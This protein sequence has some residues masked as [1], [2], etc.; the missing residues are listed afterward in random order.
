M[1]N[2][3]FVEFAKE[4]ERRE[5]VKDDVIVSQGAI[6][7]LNP[8][9][10]AIGD[11]HFGMNKYAQNQV[12]NK[13]G[14][15]VK[16]YDKAATIPGL[17]E[18]NI[19]T[20]LGQEPQEKRFVRTLDG[21]IR[22]FLSDRF[23]PLDNYEVMSESIVPVLQDLNNVEIKSSNIS[24]TRMYL[25]VIFKNLV[26]E[27][28]GDTVAYGV[29][30][31]NSEVGAGAFDIRSWTW[32]LRCTNGAVHE[33]IFRRAH[34]G[35]VYDPEEEG[36]YLKSDTIQKILIAQKGKIRD[37]L[38]WAIKGDEFKRIISSYEAADNDVIP[39]SSISNTVENV[40]R[41]YNIP[42]A[43]DRIVYNM[44][45]ERLTRYGLA[46][47]ITALSHSEDDIDRQ[48]EYEKIGGTMLTMSSGQFKSQFA[49]A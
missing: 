7:M 18:F 43:K 41:K 23:L 25:Q 33:S 45:K 21:N 31:S 42:G 13:L 22:A 5:T 49:A 32:I 2:T 35:G 29:T 20:L 44:G 40:T 28:L 19:N 27:V 26:A 36:S 17:L 12:A 15:P 16:Y 37:A 39:V 38:D 46:N 3:N 30:I 4:L 34:I 24:D 14:I 6:Q 10:V 1:K 9:L 47:A 48:F 11:R 8:E